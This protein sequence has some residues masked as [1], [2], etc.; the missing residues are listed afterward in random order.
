MFFLFTYLHRMFMNNHL[1]SAILVKLICCNARVLL[2]WQI[3]CERAL[4]SRWQL[5]SCDC[6]VKSH[7]N[8]VDLFLACQLEIQR[9]KLSILIYCWLLCDTVL[10]Q[11][12]WPLHLDLPPPIG[13]RFDVFFRNHYM[14]LLVNPS[15]AGSI[16]LPI[17]RK[18]IP[19]TLLCLVGGLC[20]YAYYF[21]LLFLLTFFLYY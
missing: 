5:C 17:V 20:H 13:T 6:P 3:V 1:V 15:Q 12:T 16:W 14:F 21:L 11:G 19:S 8:K 7:L 10:Y 9:L 2:L 18:A 4:F